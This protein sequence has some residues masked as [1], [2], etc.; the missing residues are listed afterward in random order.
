MLNG[1]VFNHPEVRNPLLLNE[2]VLVC[3]SGTLDYSYP[4]LYLDA[5]LP[6]VI[7]GLTLGLVI[8]GSESWAAQDSEAC[9]S[10]QLGFV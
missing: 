2:T 8:G 1:C 7:C 4:G 9:A 3:F 5:C 10:L 6:W